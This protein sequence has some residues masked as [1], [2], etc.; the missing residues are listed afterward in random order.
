[1]RISKIFASG[2]AA[3]ALVASATFG[4]TAPASAHAELEGSNP[5]ANA[6]IGALPEYLDL[7][8]G[9]NI[10]TIDGS[11]GSNQIQVV[12]ANGA[13]VDDETIVIN[14]QVVSVGIKPGFGDS[15][16]TVT[17]RVVSED[18]HPIEGSYNFTVGEA[19]QSVIATP[20]PISAGPID[21]VAE[22]AT[23][24]TDAT[25]WFVLGGVIVVGAAAAIMLVL[26]RRKV[27][28]VTTME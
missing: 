11:E 10:M 13:R 18:G 27:A 23:S 15:T 20:M 21:D 7:T 26:R 8:F 4:L 3:L 5:E 6:L 1:M 19:A 16:Y 12:D 9:E 24:G 25:L 22:E 28:G 14:N 17:Y 2:F